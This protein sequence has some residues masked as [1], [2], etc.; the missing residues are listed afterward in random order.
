MRK[1]RMILAQ[2]RL[3]LDAAVSFRGWCAVLL[4]SVMLP[5]FA[6]TGGSFSFATNRFAV[7]EGDGLALVVIT[8]TSDVGVM[9]VD[10]I[11]ENGTATNGVDFTLDP[12]TNTIVFSHFQTAVTVPIE[13]SDNST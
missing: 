6:Q 13:V 3:S 5:S 11:A 1:V 8:R 4:L 12:A 9:M 10:L 7:S 2:V